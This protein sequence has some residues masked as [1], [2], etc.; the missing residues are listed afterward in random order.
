M[1]LAAHASSP[2]TAQALLNELADSQ[3]VFLERIARSIPGMLPKAYRWVGEMEEISSFVRD[4]LGD[5]EAHIHHGFAHLYDRIEKAL[6]EGEDIKVLK[7]FVEDAKGVARKPG[8]KTRLYPQPPSA[9][10]RVDLKGS[11]L[12]NMERLPYD[13]WH[14]IFQ[15]ACTDGGYTGCA[16]AS[17]SKSVRSIS[18]AARLHSVNLHSLRQVQLFLVC[19]ERSHHP[20]GAETPPVHHLFLSFVPQTCDAPLRKFRKTTHYAH[21]ERSVLQQLINDHRE[22]NAAKVAWNHGFV[23]HITRLLQAVAPSLRTLTVVQARQ[24]RLPLLWYNLPALRELT[25]FGDDRLFLRLP[26]PGL[27]VPGESDDSDFNTYGVSSFPATGETSEPTCVP[28]PSLERLH[29][30]LAYPKLHPWK[31]TLPHWAALAP[32][33]THLRL[34]GDDEQV[35]QTLRRV[36]GLPMITP[37]GPPSA[38]RSEL[39]DDVSSDVPT[40][41]YPDLSL[42]M[43]QMGEHGTRKPGGGAPV[44]NREAEVGLRPE[45]KKVAA[46]CDEGPYSGTRTVFVRGQGPRMEDWPKRLK[47]DWEER[48]KGEVGCWTDS[49]SEDTDEEGFG[50]G[51]VPPTAVPISGQQSRDGQRGLMGV[52]REAIDLAI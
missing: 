4:G 46:L 43:V 8:Q 1:I 26:Q 21:N 17:T 39:P 13:I 22:W 16:L 40:S 34:S 19:L 25:L 5:G 10:L 14:I 37:P 12:N 30:V 42:V 38:D 35:L 3:P 20:A 7:K 41:P 15:Q 47:R 18:A 48:M 50:D 31:Q 24:I 33:L 52:R 23:L 9:R 29:V 6:P 45:V 49:A 28:F 11:V 32:R 2:A 44:Q 27:L 51:I 36:L